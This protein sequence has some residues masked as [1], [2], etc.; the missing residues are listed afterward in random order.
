MTGF[1]LGVLTPIVIYGAY[2]LLKTKYP[3]K[4]GR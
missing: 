3:A 4:G 2:K 1:L